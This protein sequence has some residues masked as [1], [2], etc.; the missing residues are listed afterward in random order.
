[1][2]GDTRE[3]ARRRS[4]KKSRFGYYLYAV[5]VF[6]LTI[7]NI[8]LAIWLLTYV[9]NIQV[10]GNVNSEKSEVVEWMQEDPMTINSLYTVWKFKTGAYKLPV[11]LEDADVRLQAPWK[12]EVTVREKEVIGCVIHEDEY[13]YFDAEGLV[14]K[15][16]YE[17][18]EGVPLIEGLEVESAGRFSYLKVKNEKVFSY[19]VNLTKEIEKKELKPNRIQW[20]EESMDLYFG[21]I[22][23]KL[24]RNN[25]E[26]KLAEIPPILEKLE[27]KK[28][29]LHMEYYEKGSTISF[30]ENK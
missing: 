21:D 3:R 16:D 10:K 9:Q 22:C 30:K 24:G 2:E 4:R 6:L 28:G 29:V 23:V 8:S 1:M 26:V 5:T 13:V 12:V 27:G 18:M 14:L 15:E 17:L 19:I 25:Y 11:Y 7:I 20:M